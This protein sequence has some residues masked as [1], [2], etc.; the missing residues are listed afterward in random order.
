MRRN[1]IEHLIRAAAAITNECEIMIIGSQSILWLVPRCARRIASI[2][3][4]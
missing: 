3:G 4:S 2:H 1:E